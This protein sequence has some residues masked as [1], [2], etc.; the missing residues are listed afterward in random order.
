VK[1]SPVEVKILRAMHKGVPFME[2]LDHFY[3]T[4]LRGRPKTLRRF[5]KHGLIK[6]QA[7]YSLQLTVKGE[8]LAVS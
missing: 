8:R 5:E 1:L 3:G 7:T 6:L 4:D 2:A